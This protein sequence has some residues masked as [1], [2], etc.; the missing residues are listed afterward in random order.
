MFGGLG[1]GPF[2]KEKPFQTFQGYGGG[3]GGAG[4]AGAGQ[5]PI[6]ATGG[7]KMTDGDYTF[8][9]WGSN[10][11]GSQAFWVSDG[12]PW[13]IDILVCGGGGGGAGKGGGGGGG[14]AVIHLM[15]YVIDGAPVGTYPITRGQSGTGGPTN[16]GGTGGQTSVF[17]NSTPTPL[18][19]VGGGG[20]GG[21]SDNGDP[22]GS[23]GGGGRG[24]SN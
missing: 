8:H 3:A 17:G 10:A 15:E 23:G 13:N 20:G 16:Q 19:A 14:G 22:G 7:T 5:S 4:M 21:S 1:L 6:T 9:V 24:D 2:K 12:G 18:S 11:P